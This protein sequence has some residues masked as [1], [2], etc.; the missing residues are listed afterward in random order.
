MPLLTLT[1]P[2]GTGKT[3]LALQ[4]AAEVLDAAPLEGAPDGGPFPDGAW[5][6]DLAPLTDPALVP[7]AVAQ[8]LGVRESGGRPLAAALRDSLREKRL[9][10]VL[11]NCEH[12]LPAAAPLV[13]GLLAAGPGVRVLATSR[14]ALRVAGEHEHPVPPLGLPPP[15]RCARRGRPTRRPPRIRRPSLSTRRWPC[16]WSGRWPPSRTS[17]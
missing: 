15:A 10:L 13:A 14:E 17:S 16:S 12:L 8:A 11:D 3:R 7:D 2:G 6:V 5:F 4:A 1:G 9:L